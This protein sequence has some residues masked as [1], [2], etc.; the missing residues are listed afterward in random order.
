MIAGHP[1]GT[2]PDPF[3]NRI[4]GYATMTHA[5]HRMM[6]FRGMAS[7]KRDFWLWINSFSMPNPRRRGHSLPNRGR[8]DKEIDPG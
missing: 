7:I 3:Y 2:G 4:Y 6:S 8:N 1:F 5:V